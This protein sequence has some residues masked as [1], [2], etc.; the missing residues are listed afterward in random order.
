MFRLTTDGLTLTE[1]APGIDVRRDVIERMQF[2]AAHPARAGIDDGR[3]FQPLIGGISHGTSPHR[4]HRRRPDR[5]QHISGAALGPSRLHARRRRRSVARAR[6]RRPSSSAIRATP[7]I[8]EMLDKA[9]PDGA[10]VAVP[11]QMHVSVGLACVAR[12]IP[13]IIEKPVADTVAEALKL[14]EAAEKAGVADPHR[15]SPP[16][17]P[18]HAQGRRDHARGRHRPGRR[19]RPRSG[20]RTSPKDYFTISP[21]GASPAAG[22]C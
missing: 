17:Q 10:I 1:V 13:I 21:G 7:T 12:K 11:N 16:P 9:K 15:P 20:C 3:A 19:R 4:R 2:A 22:R 14:V 5:P 6:S 18:D 8:E